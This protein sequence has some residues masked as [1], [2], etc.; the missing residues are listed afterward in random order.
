MEVKI[1]AALLGMALL[2]AASVASAQVT[3]TITGTT[4]GNPA[5]LGVGESITLEIAV[6]NP[7][8]E[9]VQ[10]NGRVGLRLQ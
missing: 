8:N 2:L 6:D 4:G 1:R 10:G 3:V 5:A 9:S 7:T